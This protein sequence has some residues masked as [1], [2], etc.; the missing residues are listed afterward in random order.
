MGLSHSSTYHSSLMRSVS[1]SSPVIIE[2]Y[3]EIYPRLPIEDFIG[4]DNETY[5]SQF[6]L[7]IQSYQAMYDRPYTDMRSYFQVAGIHSQP[8]IAYDG[9]TGG[10]QEYKN[11]TDWARGRWGGYCHHGDVLFGPW[12]R[13]YLL[14]MESLL[15]NESKKIALQYPENER[16]KYVEAANQLRIPYW[17]WADV[18]AIKGI[19]DVFTLTELEINTPEGMKKVK[20]PLRSY[21][22]PVDLAFPLGKGYNPTDKPHYEIPSFGFNPFTPAGY[23][24]VRY[25]N[26]NYEDQIDYLNQNISV[27][28]STVLRPLVY[29][30]LQINNYLQFSNHA[31]RSNDTEAPGVYPAHPLP[32]VVAGR[33]HFASI[34][35]AHDAI[36]FVV[37][38]PGGHFLYPDLG[39]FDPVFFFHHAAIDRLLALWQ[40]TWV[41]ENVDINGTYTEDLYTVVNEDSDLTPFRKSETEFWKSSTVRDIE[42]LGYTYPELVKFKGQDPRELQAYLLKFYKPDPHYGR[43]FFVKLIIDAG[44]LVGPYVIRVFLDLQNASVETPVTSPHFAGFVAMWRRASP[45]QISGTTYVM[46]SV[47][48]TAAMERAFNTPD[49]NATTG[50]LSSSAIFDIQSDIN[51]VPCYLNGTGVNPKEAGVDEVEIY[52]FEHD[53]VDPDFLVEDS[54]QYYYTKKF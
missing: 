5:S 1:E 16:E 30:M 21:T 44:K 47:D 39:G 2:P 46:G 23:S 4:C 54:V 52:S 41:T 9:V 18:K 22:I 49:V 13:P 32:L 24:T 7:I 40:A 43:R 29:Q 3:S 36:H 42:K 34:E 51:I 53:K 8:W 45:Y 25:P 10:A 19:P 27:Y 20:N 35:T 37:G 15:I 33:A 50:L 14:L 38:G 6:E 28:V 11:E 12:H 48:I 17:D 31:L 26:A